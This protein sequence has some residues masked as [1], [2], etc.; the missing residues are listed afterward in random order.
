MSEQ[1]SLEI[2][3]EKKL[4]TV[5][6]YKF[7]PIKGYPMLQWKG[8][9]PFTSTQFYP[10]QLKENH[11]DAVKG[12]MNRI[13]WGD[14]LQVMSHLLKEFRGK[15]DLVYID[16]PFDSKADYKKQIR[17]KSKTTANDLNAFEEKQYH[18]MWTN[19]QF[20]QFIYE[21]AVLLREL[22]SSKGSLYFHCDYQR[23]AYVRCILDEVFGP[24]SFQ[25]EIVWKRTTA[26]SDSSYY[27]HIHDTILFYTKSSSAKWNQQYTAYSK[28]YL[29]S[30]FQPDANG[31]LWRESPLT[32]PGTRDGL[33]G[34]PWRGVNPSEIGKGRHW[35]IPDFVRPLLSEAARANPLVALDELQ[36]K[37]RIYWAKEGKG[38][39]N[40]IQYKEDMPGVGIQSIWTDFSA[41]SGSS[42]E[43][44]G[45][46]TQKPEALLRRII[47]SSSDPGDLVL[48]CFMGSGTTQTV[49]MKHGR[50]FIGADINLGAIQT[51]TKRLITVANGLLQSQVQG[52]F[53]SNGPTGV[54]ILR[55]SGF[56]V[57]N[58]NHYDV[59]RNPVQAKDLLIEA[60]EIQ[61]LPSNALYDGEKDGR[62]VKVMP[63]NRIATKADINDLLTGFDY[64]AFQKRRESAPNKPV[65]SLLL[66]CM[67]HEPDLAA[68]LKRECQG[69]DLDVEV[70]DILRDK[71]NL[72]FKRDA[73]AE[74][75]VEK[76]SLKITA[77][78]PMNLLQKL[79]LMKENV[80][81]W[82]ELTE[83]VMIDWNYDGAVFEPKLVDVPEKEELV[84]GEYPVPEGA[85]TI[86]VKLTD[87]L[88]ESLE[89]EV[90]RG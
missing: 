85:G 1:S 9:R 8:K 22:L 36:D 31:R 11:G 73:Q 57:Y 6:D 82:R 40:V 42:A 39:P 21:R 2:K 30:N 58:V 87:L 81:D 5:E 61:P 62:M 77:F 27:G 34:Q 72:E 86:R 43:N 47:L 50:R 37:G 18:D 35:S 24:A 60:M 70:V 89:A 45:Y 75:K 79:S 78:Y 49:A 59:F 15:V 38:R 12:W 20:L 84:K 23:S 64:K 4:S 71:A 16:P 25:N 88:S 7:E 54:A 41:L 14:N 65:E 29:D 17:V 74:I 46:P 13:Y 69:F 53:P 90:S 26:R 76:G 66:V 56:S 68:H 33:S 44:T 67:G 83:S 32:A 28:E 10:A 80:G 3:D 52:E 55:Y 63:I 19:D 48:D 51:A